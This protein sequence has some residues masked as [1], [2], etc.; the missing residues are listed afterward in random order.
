[1]CV[2]CSENF[3]GVPAPGAPMLPTPVMKGVVKYMPH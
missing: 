2:S 1:M 3:M